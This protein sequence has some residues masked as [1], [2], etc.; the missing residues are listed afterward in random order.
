[1]GV[2]G[3]GCRTAVGS[4]ADPGVR[5]SPRPAAAVRGSDTHTPIHLYTHTHTIRATSHA[6]RSILP[7]LV[8]ISTRFDT[9]GET[10]YIYRRRHT[11]AAS[12]RPHT[13]SPPD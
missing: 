2:W 3:Y 4:G 9:L 13:C 5:G 7:P 11:S 1:M 12:R 8:P 6:Y 10:C